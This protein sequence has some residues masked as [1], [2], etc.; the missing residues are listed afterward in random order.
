MENQPIYKDNNFTITRELFVSGNA[1]FAIQHLCSIRLV[2]SRRQIPYALLVLELTLIATGLILDFRFHEYV[3]LLGG[4]GLIANI[5]V[6]ILVKPVHKLTLVFSSGE[7]EI[8]GVTDYMYL[9]GLANAFSR[10]ITETR[11]KNLMV[12]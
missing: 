5:L 8:I 9:E 3:S 10:S 2:K 6:Y 7:K 1:R 4:A 11:H 12:G